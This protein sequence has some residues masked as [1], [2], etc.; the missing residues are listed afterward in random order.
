MRRFIR[1][2]TFWFALASVAYAQSSDVVVAP[3]NVSQGSSE[4]QEGSE[5]EVGDE[6]SEL[7]LLGQTKSDAGESRRNENVQIDPIDNNALRELNIRMGTTATLV[8]EFKVDRNYF[9]TE[10]GASPTSSPHA[11]P[12]PAGSIHGEIS[13]GHDNSELRARSFFQVGD[14]LPARENSFGATITAPLGR[15]VSLS[16]DGSRTLVRGNVNG[17][18]LV[19]LANE[20]TPLTT[21]PEERALVESFLGAY[22]S[23]A[24]N[25][26]DINAR[27]LNT[28][29]PQQIDTDAAGMRLTF[30]QKLTLQYRF[31]AQQVDAFQLVAGQNPDTTVR[32]HA[33]RITWNR[34][35]G[36]ST[37]AEFTVGLDRLG[38][39]LAP[40]TNA[41]GPTVQIGNIVEDLGPG[42]RIPVD[43]AQNDFRYAA[44]FNHIR[45]KHTLTF[46]GELMR[47][48]FNGV[49]VSSRRGVYKFSNNFGRDALTNLRMGT[50][51]RFSTGIG[52][53]H[54]GFRDWRGQAYL[55]DSWRASSDL[56][57][58]MGV[59][60]EPISSPYEVDGL[61][62]I[63]YPCD[64]NN[65][66]GH[67]G[68]A[69]RL[70]RRWG[71]LR[72]SGG[73]HYAEV[74]P[75][76]YQQA[77]F[78][79][80]KIFKLVVQDASLLNPLKGV[81]EADLDPDSP[82][83]RIILD[84]ELVSPYSLQYNFSWQLE[85]VKDWKLRLG[86]VG[87]RS[88]KLLMKWALNRGLRIPGIALTSKTVNERR[89]DSG[90]FDIRRVSNESRGYYDAARATLIVPNWRGL[91]VEASY[92]FSKAIDLGTSYTDTA[93]GRSSLEGRS[94]TAENIGDDLRG[95]S[96]FDQPHALLFRASYEIPAQRGGSRLLGKIFGNWVVS[97]VTLAKSGTP[98]TVISGS[99]SP[100][101][102]NVDGSTGD[103]PHLL[104]TSLLGRTI[105]HPDT[106]PALLPAS[107]FAFIRPEEQAGTLGRNT[108]RKAPIANVNFALSRTWQTGGDSRLSFRAESVNAFNTPQF[109]EPGLTLSSPDFAQ[110]TNT[111]NDGRSF[112]FELTWVF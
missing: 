22:P 95:L 27:A 104:D 87:S 61:T 11:A 74:L 36:A 110:I 55:G 6:R 31:T 82:A 100:G 33:A 42:S 91:S 2:I 40:E 35:W 60:Y 98:F 111:L 107:A 101:F 85:P 49:Q 3:E 93:S 5:I 56:T 57:V 108:F 39:L 12:A 86:Y 68:L 72:A 84:D 73:L 69:Q 97:S 28:N 54:R 81:T 10:F 99:D 26:T 75:A 80:P 90:A 71:V 76:T 102:G 20:R 38:S 4:A 64:C 29:S 96:S 105:G 94:Q 44:G 67:F 53:P 58:T 88:Q 16:A 83:T 65:F 23:E 47:R 19:P 79:P 89:P 18:V 62:E 30:A 1:I 45:G 70:P 103:R 78:N 46:G 41:V 9:G 43:R 48:Q 7:N 106:A 34:S 37:T 92:W 77:R 50:P 32:S 15:T 14:V 112:R 24:P 66:G 13:F 25:R 51:S 8:E 17:N 63:P 21:D 59:R 52:D 109:A